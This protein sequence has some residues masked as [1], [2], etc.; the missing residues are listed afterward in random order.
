[1]IRLLFVVSYFLSK[2][3]LSWEILKLSPVTFKEGMKVLQ[4]WNDEKLATKRMS[5]V[6]A[7]SLAE[8]WLPIQVEDMCRAFERQKPITRFNHV[9][10]GLLGRRVIREFRIAGW[11]LNRASVFVNKRIE[12]EIDKRLNRFPEGYAG[13]GLWVTPSQKYKKPENTPKDQ[14]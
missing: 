7:R 5:E 4:T 3:R 11:S 2:F 14:V 13:E 12:E 1:M 9:F 10:Y 6:L 8:K